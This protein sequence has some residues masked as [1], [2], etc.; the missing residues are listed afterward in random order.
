[1]K[2]STFFTS[3]AQITRDKA[4]AYGMN[5]D[6]TVVFPWGVDLKHFSA[7]TIIQLAKNKKRKRQSAKSKR[8]SFVLFCNRSWEPR[9][10]VDVLARAFVKVAN[11]REDV[12]LLLLN[13]GSQTN[14]IRQILMNGGVLDRVQFG[15]QVSQT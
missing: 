8:K 3:D 15:G 5:P 14:V 4:I 13:G 10:G 6:R 1:L 9:Y 12:S 2:R 11:Q 7:G